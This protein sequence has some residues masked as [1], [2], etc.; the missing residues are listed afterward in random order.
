MTCTAP[1]GVDAVGYNGAFVKSVAIDS[2]RVLIID[3]AHVL[4]FIKAML[5]S[6]THARESGAMKNGRA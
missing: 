5:E 2:H 1:D 4:A 6:L 3:Q